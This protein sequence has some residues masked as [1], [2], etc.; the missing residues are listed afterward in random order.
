VVGAVLILQASVSA[1]LALAV[2]LLVLNAMA[3]YRW[4]SSTA[5]WTAAK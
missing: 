1:A 2:V 5:A 4:S 3:G